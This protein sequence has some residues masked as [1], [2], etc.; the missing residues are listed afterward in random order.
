MSGKLA[1]ADGGGAVD[2]AA[3]RAAVEAARAVADD[4]DDVW[5]AAVRPRC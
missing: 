3:V 5:E 1:R 4:D 2:P